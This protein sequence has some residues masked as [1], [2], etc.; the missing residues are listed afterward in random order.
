MIKSM[1]YVLKCRPGEVVM[2]QVRQREV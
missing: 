2:Q 1:Q